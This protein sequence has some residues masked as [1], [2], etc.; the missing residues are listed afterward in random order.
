MIFAV[1]AG[2]CV[3]LISV[4]PPSLK[5]LHECDDASHQSA[6]V[7]YTRTLALEE[8]AKA[9]EPRKFNELL[10]MIFTDSGS[11]RWLRDSETR[12]RRIPTGRKRHFRRRPTN[13]PS[14]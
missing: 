6:L 8:W 13:E 2:V 9:G 1:W 3:A 7:I 4:I 14:T 11:R 5:F 10:V 12:I